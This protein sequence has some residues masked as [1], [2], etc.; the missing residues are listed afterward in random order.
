ML[1]RV[2]SYGASKPAP[3]GGCAAARRAPP[4]RA[5]PP[6]RSGRR[7]YQRPP[8]PGRGGRR[9]WPGRGSPSPTWSART[10]CSTASRSGSASRSRRW[11]RPVTTGTHSAAGPN[12]SAP[13]PTRW[14]P[15][16]GRSSSAIQTR[17]SPNWSR[18]SWTP[19]AGC[20][21]RPGKPQDESV[22]RGAPGP[23]GKTTSRDPRRRRSR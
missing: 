14:R 19:S 18:S 13:Q 22:G 16:P 9:R 12:G 17:G 6:P 4:P 5:R 7:R 23:S 3:S 21:R 15:R 10:S 8:R 2:W 20:G 1:R 11:R